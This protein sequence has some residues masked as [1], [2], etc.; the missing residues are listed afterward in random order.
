M[1]SLYQKGLMGLITGKSF[2]NES[3]KGSNTDAS[4]FKLQLSRLI[5]LLY[6]HNERRLPT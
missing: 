6:K 2:R 1:I 3:L 4:V 5:I